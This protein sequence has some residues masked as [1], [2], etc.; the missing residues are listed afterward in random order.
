[1]IGRTCPECGVDVF[2][3]RRWAVF[4]PP[5]WPLLAALVAGTG[6][7][8]GLLAY[9]LW[10]VRARGGAVMDAPSAVLLGML[11]TLTCAAMLATLAGL[12]RRRA[13]KRALGE[14]RGRLALL[15]GTPLLAAG[16]SWASV[17]GVA[18]LA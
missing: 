15:A 13:M 11:M 10:L 4:G 6:A 9:G 5:A 18:I 16:L 1:M 14:A 3:E 17:V 7:W 12:A 2:A 8:G